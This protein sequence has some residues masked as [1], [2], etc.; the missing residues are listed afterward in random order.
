MQWLFF[1]GL[2]YLLDCT[3]TISY[4]YQGE[5]DEDVAYLQKKGSGMPVMVV[6]LKWNKS[7]DGAIDQ[8]KVR[9]YLEVFEG[10]GSEAL[11]V[12]GSY[13]E[14]TKKHERVIEKWRIER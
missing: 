10:Y 14:K 4:L 13:D 2:N 12:G 5:A 8:I 9:N 7:A 11:L 3:L 6:E 1:D